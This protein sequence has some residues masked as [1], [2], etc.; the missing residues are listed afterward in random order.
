MQIAQVMSGF[1]LGEAVASRAM[2]KK[3]KRNAGAKK[4]IS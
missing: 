3:I 1:S 4:Q 2:G